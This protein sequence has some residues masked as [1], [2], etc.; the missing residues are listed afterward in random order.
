MIENLTFAPITE[1]FKRENGKIEDIIIAHILMAQACA[2]KEKGICQSCH[3]KW[4]CFLP[5]LYIR[6]MNL[7]GLT[8]FE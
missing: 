6:R 2:A 1:T 7:E 5:Y 8:E 3:M 4:I